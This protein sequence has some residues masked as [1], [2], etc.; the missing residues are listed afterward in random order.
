MNLKRLRNL[1]ELFINE[2]FYI[3]DLLL[4]LILNYSLDLLYSKV[5]KVEKQEE[6]LR[7]T[8]WDIMILLDA[9]RYDIFYQIFVSE[10]R[11]ILKSMRCKYVLKP[12]I[13][14][15]TNTYDWFKKLL[16]M[17]DWRDTV[18]LCPTPI[19]FAKHN[20]RLRPIPLDR[21]GKVIHLWKRAWNHKLRTIHPLRVYLA[22]KLHRGKYKGHK[23]IV[24]FLQ[25]HYPYLTRDFG[26]K[27]K[28]EL[29][30]PHVRARVIPISEVKEAYK[31]NLRIVLKYVLEIIRS[32]RGR[33]ILTSDHGEAFLD[34][35][36]IVDHSS[37]IRVPSLV[38]VPF[39]YV[40]HL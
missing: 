29:F 11:H 39:L 27:D 28:E 34:L 4:A 7:K 38:V 35:G 5:F 36:F 1:L 10:Y 14:F 31:E 32:T 9:C 19:L 33:I 26:Y 20:R 25:P 21:F 23:V 12:V 13:S 24:H 17:R 18:Y 3:I 30:W 22:Y 15:A 8:R 37:H 40:E 2:L 6:A 16:S